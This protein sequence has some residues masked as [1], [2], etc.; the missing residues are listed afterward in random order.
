MNNVLILSHFL[1]PS[2]TPIATICRTHGQQGQKRTETLCGM[3]GVHGANVHAPVVEELPILS[4]VVSVPSKPLPYTLAELI[5]C[6]RSSCYISAF[7]SV[8]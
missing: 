6:Y 4:G 7:M 3:P 1:C 5:L 2:P 8:F